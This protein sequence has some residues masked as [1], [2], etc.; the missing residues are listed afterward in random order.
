MGSPAYDPLIG[1]VGPC[2]AGKTSLAGKLSTQ[3]SRVRAIA[4]EHSYV[5]DMWRRIT[6][7]DILIYL[8]ASYAVT[9][10]R[11]NLSWSESEYQIELDRL[12][13]SRA[14]ADIIIV[15]DTLT[16]DEV[17]RVAMDRLNK[18]NNME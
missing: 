4:Q 10:Q 3:Y 18:L 11:R 7:P 2:G 12:A 1:I 17:F 5:P 14:N 9:I 15:T 16:L 8:E 6:N 13:H